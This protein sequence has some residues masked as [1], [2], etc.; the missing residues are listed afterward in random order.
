MKDKLRHIFNYISCSAAG[1]FSYVLGSIL[2]L[3]MVEEGCGII[4]IIIL[5]VLLTQA[6]NE[7]VCEMAKTKT[8]YK[9]SVFTIIL[10]MLSVIVAKIVDY[11]GIGSLFSIIYNSIAVLSFLFLLEKID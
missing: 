7:L 10:Y 4:A 8:C 1:I 5:P 3:L 2:M 9:L 11:Q 6:A